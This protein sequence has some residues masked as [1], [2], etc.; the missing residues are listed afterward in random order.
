MK[1][2]VASLVILA[3]TTLVGPGC[4]E[5]P[6]AEKITASASLSGMLSI[7]DTTY[8]LNEEAYGTALFTQE[9]SVVTLSIH[10]EN[11]PPNTFHAV[12]LHEGSCEQPG[13]H[14]NQGFDV[15]TRFC[16][17]RSI[18]IPWAKPMAGDVGNISVGY[19]GTGILILDTDLWRLGSGDHRDILGKTIVVHDTF[20]DFPTECDPSHG[21]NHPHANAKIA[22]GTITSSNR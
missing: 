3:C 8:Q 21:H 13:M 19:D 9:D 17:T 2:N 1:T 15:T 14:W 12:H 18:G 10:L 20:E 6:I 5:D 4:K 22:C 7:T 16:N 11:F